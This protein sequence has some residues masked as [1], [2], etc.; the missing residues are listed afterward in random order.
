MKRKARL[1]TFF[2]PKR[3]K[4]EERKTKNIKKEM[5]VLAATFCVAYIIVFNRLTSVTTSIPEQLYNI[6]KVKVID[7][8]GND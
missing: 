3:W 8:S 4:T 6:I 5:V 1:K 2:I 7:A